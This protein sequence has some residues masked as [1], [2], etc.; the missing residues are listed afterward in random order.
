LPVYLNINN[1]DIEQAFLSMQKPIADLAKCSEVNINSTKIPKNVI[2]SVI[3]DIEISLVLDS[4]IDLDSEIKR[5]EKEISRL[6]NNIQSTEKKLSND[7][8]LANAD[9]EIINY[10]KEKLANMIS[11]RDKVQNNLEKIKQITN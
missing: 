8:F 2:T 7:K 3:R 9:P 6:S 5:L 10:E 1:K 11:S 4:K